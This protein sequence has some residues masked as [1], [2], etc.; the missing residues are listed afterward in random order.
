MS[1]LAHCGLKFVAA[2]VPV[3]PDRDQGQQW[4]LDELS[5]PEYAAAKPTWW[6]QLSKAVWDWFNSLSLDGGSASQVPLLVALLLIVA[7]V[8]VAAYFIFGRPRL[9][10]RSAAIGSLFGDDEERTSEALRR[11]ANA[12]A[13]RA[14]WA[15]A[16]EE[17]FRSLARAMAER[18][19]VTTDPGTTASGFAA[20]A[21]L[22]FSD[23]S[24]QLTSSAAIFDNVR[25][26][27]RDGTEADYNTLA[28]LERELR[29]ASAPSSTPVPLEAAR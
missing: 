4:I 19:L 1:A 24:H 7:G 3:D 15:L 25:Y 11:A 29:S 9:N 8:I 17:L 10:R 13:V 27:G 28:Q 14:D 6:D 23:H 18:V 5:K 12:A 26:L 20:R 16:I 21:G 22:I 2:D